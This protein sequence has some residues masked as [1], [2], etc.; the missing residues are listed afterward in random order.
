[1][2]NSNAFVPPSSLKLSVYRT[3]ELEEAEIWKVGE[4]YVMPDRQKPILAR[5]DLIAVEFSGW[6]LEFE[7]DGIPYPRHCNVIN[8]PAESEWLQLARD[9]ADAAV[10]RMAL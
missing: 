8:W 1:M 6:N 2:S 9:L 10:L 5:A 3:E 4:E 7:P